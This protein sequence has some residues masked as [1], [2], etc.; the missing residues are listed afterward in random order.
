[1]LSLSV[2]IIFALALPLFCPACALMLPSRSL[3]NTKHSLNMMKNW[4]QPKPSTPT[5]PF[6]RF[7]SIVIPPNY[8]VAFSCLGLG[9]VIAVCLQNYLLGG[10]LLVLGAFLML[11]TGKVR[12][13]FDEDAVEVVVDKGTGNLDKTRYRHSAHFSCTS[14]TL[15]HIIVMP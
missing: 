8:N 12:F 1:M 13:L 4:F 9:A 5:K 2:A 7:E 14:L 11:Q 10:F 15:F 3:S 6:K